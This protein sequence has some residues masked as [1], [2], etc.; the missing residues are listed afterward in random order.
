VVATYVYVSVRERS[1]LNVLTPT[2]AFLVPANYLLELYHLWLFGPSGSQYAY[3]LMYACYTATFIGFA[4]G[5]LKVQLPALR[6]PFTAAE[7]AGNG[8][9]PYLVL[10]AAVALYWPVLSEF[11]EELA[12]P[13]QIYEQT[14]SGYGAYFF[15]STT[16]CYLALV[17]LLF[18]RRR[19]RFELALFTLTCLVFLWLHGSKGQMLLVVFVLAVYQVYVRARSVS[20]VSFALFGAA[21]GAL[22]LGLFLIVNPSLLVNSEDLQG[23]A[24]Y[25]DYTRNGLLVIDSDVGPLYGRLSVEQQIYSRVPRPLFPDKPNDYG[26][27]YL[28]E[29]FFPDAFQRGAGAPAF[30]F[31]IELADFGVLALPFLLLE[32]LLG[33]MLLRMFMK[34]LRRHQGP[35]DFIMVLSASGLSLIPLSGAFLLPEMLILA[36]TANILHSMRL[37]PRRAIAAAGGSG[38]QAT[39]ESPPGGPAAPAAPT[40][41]S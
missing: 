15:L 29:H 28:A 10:A 11:R 40:A 6:L 17:L 21:L 32:S 33:G 3:A 35:G 19:R 18:K 7:A 20:L 13:R 9:A 27:L 22:G 4:L 2:F 38:A 16:L 25:S 31:G 14:R 39:F 8:T 34:G 23:I 37:S 12:H 24:A 5:Y 36:I 26:A 1:Y 41:T 30:S